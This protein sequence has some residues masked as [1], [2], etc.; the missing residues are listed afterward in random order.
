MGAN[1]SDER[2]QGLRTGVGNDLGTQMPETRTEGHAVKMSDTTQL[3]CDIADLSLCESL[4]SD[5]HRLPPELDQ[6]IARLKLA[7]MGIQIDVLTGA[8][9]RYL[10]SWDQGT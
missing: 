9:E 3:T 7:G 10:G 5:V 2:A 4:A 8:Q 1:R 6:D